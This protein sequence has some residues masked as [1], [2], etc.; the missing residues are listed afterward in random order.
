MLIPA[1]GGGPPPTPLVCR[2]RPIECVCNGYQNKIYTQLYK[3]QSSQE[4]YDSTC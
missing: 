3:K 1:E 4:C 2:D